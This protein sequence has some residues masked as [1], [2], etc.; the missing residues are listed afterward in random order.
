MDN[1]KLGTAANML[2]TGWPV[3]TPQYKKK[4]GKFEQAWDRV[5]RV[6]SELDHLW[7]EAEGAGRVHPGELM[8]L[9]DL[10]ATFP[11]LQ[12][13]YWE[14]RRLF[15]ETHSGKQEATAINRRE[16][17]TGYKEKKDFMADN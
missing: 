14:D 9:G 16:A 12:R 5:T 6:V 4:E 3:F 10:T 13:S 1:A 17:F 2:K 7:G 15:G 11:Y 8:A